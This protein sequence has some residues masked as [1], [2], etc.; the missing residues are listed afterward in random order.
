M[1]QRA[2]GKAE[3]TIQA[4]LFPSLGKSFVWG[5][6]DGGTLLSDSGTLQDNGTATVAFTPTGDHKVYTVRIGCDQNN[7]G[8]LDL[9]EIIATPTTPFKVLVV[10]QNDYNQRKAHLSNGTVF[11]ATIIWRVASILLKIFLNGT[12]PSGAT[13]ST[14]SLPASTNWLTHIAGAEF[15]SPS[16]AATV[17]NYDFATGSEAGPKVEKSVCIETN[18][19]AFLKS[20]KAEVS[21]FFP[22]TAWLRMFLFGLGIKT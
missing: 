2:S 6:L 7:N 9:D 21:A 10:T 15:S 17:T 13:I 16:C 8:K 5:V 18:R 20:K 12:V 11:P 19:A 22:P 1:A 3:L 4:D 14:A